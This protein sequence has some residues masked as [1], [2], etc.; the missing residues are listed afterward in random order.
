MVVCLLFALG[1]RLLVIAVVTDFLLFDVCGVVCFLCL[2]MVV[3]FLLFCC[4]GLVVFTW[5]EFCICVA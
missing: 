1:L 5:F 4:V 3:C 2:L